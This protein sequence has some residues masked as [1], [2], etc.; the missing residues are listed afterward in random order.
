MLEA[1]LYTLGVVIFVTLLLVA[2]FRSVDPAIVRDG[3]RSCAGNWYEAELNDCKH[4]LRAIP[5]QPVNTYSNLAYVAAGFFPGF[6]LG[7]P[8]SYIFALAMLY[9]CI[10]SA[11]YHATS[12]RWAGMMDVTAIYV[13]FS[14]LAV[15]AVA[16]LFPLPDWLAPVMMPVVAG[17]VAYILSPRYHRNM[18]LIIGLFLGGTYA[19]VLLKMAISGDWAFGL[20]LLVSLLA[21]ALAYLFWSMDRARTFPFPRWGHGLWHILTAL[22]CTLVFFAIHGVGL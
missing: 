1:S 6:L 10:G 21:F 18:R 13:V 3:Y 7:T 4:G 15:C 5:Q 17:G 2:I 11:L 19:T 22:A 14:A 9:L 20:Y 16:V 8:A 12:T